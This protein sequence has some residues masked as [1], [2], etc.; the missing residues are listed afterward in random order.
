MFFKILL[1]AIIFIAI[2]GAAIAFKYFNKKQAPMCSNASILENGDNCI[3][4]GASAIE[5]CTEESKE[6]N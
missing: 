3:V 6:K 2:A 1:L 4:C 5:E